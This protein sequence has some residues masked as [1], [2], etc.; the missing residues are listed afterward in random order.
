MAT[1]STAQLV[2][3]RGSEDAESL[4][5]GRRHFLQNDLNHL[6]E[7]RDDED[8]RQRLQIFEVEAD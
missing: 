8:E 2:V 1:P 5:E 3:M 4:I 6:N 7:G